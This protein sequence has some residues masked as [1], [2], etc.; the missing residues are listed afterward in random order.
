MSKN[1]TYQVLLKIGKG[2]LCGVGV[3]MSYTAT[4]RVIASATAA[5]SRWIDLI[6]SWGLI[7]LANLLLVIY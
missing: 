2:Q 5:T 1:L 4:G 6:I 3:S 7:E